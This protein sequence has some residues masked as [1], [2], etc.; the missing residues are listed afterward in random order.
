MS[1]EVLPTP[2][3]IR[4]RREVRRTWFGYLADDN[5]E[6]V[7]QR[8][9]NLLHGRRY[10]FAS[11]NVE[12]KHTPPDV[13]TGQRLCPENHDAKQSPK[14]TRIGDRLSWGEGVANY[15]HITCADTYGSWG[16]HSSFATEA[17]AY[18]AARD[19][20]RSWQTT[21]VLIEGGSHPDDTGGRRD[22]IEIRQTNG[23]KETLW[24]VI[25][26]EPEEIP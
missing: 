24:W 14:V 6:H 1:A 4:T 2:E 8:I 26:P 13:R 9:F 22:R 17:E 5:V 18:A 10:T 15:C 7:A 23:Y 3:Q 11:T 20:S 25:I 21:Y 16:I 19:D 12:M